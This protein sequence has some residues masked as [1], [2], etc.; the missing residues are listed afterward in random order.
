MTTMATIL[1]V[2][3]H[4]D[5]RANIRLRLELD[6]HR[7][8]EAADG[9]EA[10]QYWRSFTFD[11]I[12]TAFSMPSMNGQEVIQ[13][14]SAGQPTLPIILMSDGI[15]ES[16]LLCIL[17]RFPSVRYLPKQIISTHLPIYL[18][19]ALRMKPAMSDRLSDAR[20]QLTKTV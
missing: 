4:D 16:V 2:E 1:L 17:H 3:D 6:H 13:M 14:V 5:L 20:P 7:V 8:V 15:E 19:D 9:T 12:I 18:S 10:R 11:L